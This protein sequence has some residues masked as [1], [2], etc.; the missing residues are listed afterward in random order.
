MRRTMAGALMA[1]EM[2]TA[3]GGEVVTRTEPNAGELP[4]LAEPLWFVVG[5]EPSQQ[6]ELHALDAAHGDRI[7]DTAGVRSEDRYLL[8]GT[9][10]GTRADWDQI[11]IASSPTGR[12]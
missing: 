1:A 10:F 12:H 8:S 7:V 9:I 5:N 11:P 4:P 2:M 6:V 3:C